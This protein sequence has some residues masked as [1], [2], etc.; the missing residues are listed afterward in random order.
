MLLGQLGQRC[1]DVMLL[2]SRGYSMKEIR[3]EL[4]FS[5]EAMARKTKFKCKKKLMGLL[6][7]PANTSWA[8]LESISFADGLV[9][10]FRGLVG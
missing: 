4:E 1:K 9:V 3:D 8:K 2:W 10:M 7:K 6:E 5:S